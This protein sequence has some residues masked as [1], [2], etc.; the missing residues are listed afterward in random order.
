MCHDAR[1]HERHDARSHERQD[2]RSHECKIFILLLLRVPR[3]KLVKRAK[4]HYRYCNT[5]IDRILGIGCK[6]QNV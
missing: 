2:A 5:K 1:S 6:M 3:N 4:Q